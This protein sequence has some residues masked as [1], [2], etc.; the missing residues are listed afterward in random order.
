[1]RRLVQH[2]IHSVG[3][4]HQQVLESDQVA[5]KAV[6][7]Y[8]EVGPVI[9]RRQRIGAAVLEADHGQRAHRGAKAQGAVLDQVVAVVGRRAVVVKAAADADE[10]ADVAQAQRHGI[11][12]LAVAAEQRRTPD[13]PQRNREVALG[14]QHTVEHVQGDRPVH[15]QVERFINPNAR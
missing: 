10:D 14:Q 13:L 3:V 1:M 9:R 11:G 8:P 15:M 2:R 6:Q 4:E 5:G 12:V 7:R